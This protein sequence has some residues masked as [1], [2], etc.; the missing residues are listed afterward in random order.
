MTASDPPYSVAINIDSPPDPQYVLEL[1]EAFAQIVRALNHLTRDHE[2]LEFPAEGD[3]VLRELSSAAAR[4]PQL[5]DQIAGWYEREAA[6]GKLEAVSGAWAGMP[7]MAVAAIRMR[8]DAARMTAE[9]L[10]ADI[11]SV[12]EVTSTLAA[13]ETS[14]DGGDDAG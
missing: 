7:G 12:A 1:A 13:A 4:L 10:Q 6:A 8:A 14:E 3:H 11:A 5:L 2:A 9:Q